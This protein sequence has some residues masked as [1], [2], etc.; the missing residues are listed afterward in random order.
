[1]PIGIVSGV[2]L[3]PNNHNYDVISQCH[4]S[5][6]VLCYIAFAYCVDSQM[7]WQIVIMVPIMNKLNVLINH[8][9]W[10]AFLTGMRS[11]MH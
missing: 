8:C 10:S 3:A 9:E 6:P 7:H 5:K 1:M 4:R 2:S 11:Q